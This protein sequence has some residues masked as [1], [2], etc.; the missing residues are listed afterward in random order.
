MKKIDYLHLKKI[1]QY[2][3]EFY[4]KQPL[5]PNAKSLLL[6]THQIIDLPLQLAG[7]RL[8]VSLEILIMLLCSYYVVES[9]VHFMF[10]CPL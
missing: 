3:C 8:P 4:L 5:T 6:I 7:G 9:E 2:Y 10:K 1:F